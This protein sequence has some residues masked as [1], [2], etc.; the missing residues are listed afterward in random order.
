M[1]S[2]RISRLL[3]GIFRRNLSSFGFLVLLFEKI[4]L[5]LANFTMSL[6]FPYLRGYYRSEWCHLY[7]E[8]DSSLKCDGFYACFFLQCE[9]ILASTSPWPWG[10]TEGNL[11]RNLALFQCSD[12]RGLLTFFFL[13]CL[14]RRSNPN[15][16]MSFPMLSTSCR[17]HRGCR[18]IG[19]MNKNPV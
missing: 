5:R 2:A 13:A 16:F 12:A 9:K 6:L 3:P 11:C 17:L 1:H 10:V 19:V 14:Y 18:L 8:I 4:W 15:S 7:N